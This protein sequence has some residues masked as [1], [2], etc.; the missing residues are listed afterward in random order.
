MEC[1]GRRTDRIRGRHHAR[2]EQAFDPLRR[3]RGRGRQADAAGSQNHQAQG[4][5]GLEDRRQAAQAARYRRQA[6][7]QQ[8]LCDRS[9]TAR[10]AQR[11]DQGLPGV[12]RQAQELRREQD[13]RHARREEG[14]EGQGHRRRR[15]RRHLVARQEGAR[16][17]AHR[18]GRGRGGVEIERHDRGHAQ[19][20]P[21]RDRHQWRSAERRCAEGDRRSRQEGRCGL[22]DAVPRARLHGGDERHREALGRQGRGLGAD[23]KPGSVAGG[24]VGD[25]RHSARQMRGASASISAAASAG[26]AA[27]RTMSIR[28]SRSPRNSPTCR[29]S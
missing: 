14:G 18:L 23:A 13:R 9:E 29:S 17:A 10:H 1:A 27:R 15:G 26:A 3:G 19:G 2:G 5:E 28:R 24:V 21:H 11:R 25:V 4:S 8:D 22:F 7:R 6:R 12:R 16:C 20:W